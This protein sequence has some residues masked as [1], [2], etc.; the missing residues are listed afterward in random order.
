MAAEAALQTSVLPL[1]WG[2]DLCWAGVLHLQPNCAGEHAGRAGGTGSA[3]KGE[4]A[5]VGLRFP[6]APKGLGMA[7]GGEL[8]GPTLVGLPAATTCSHMP[9]VNTT[10]LDAAGLGGS[11]S[12]SCPAL[13]DAVEH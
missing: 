2:Q 11:V 6:R 7:S 10:W 5:W 9:W 12:S 8:G 4:G 1:T 13:W 3:R